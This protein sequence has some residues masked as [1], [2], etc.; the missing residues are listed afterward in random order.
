M[1][2]CFRFT[3]T[4]FFNKILDGG[5]GNSGVSWEPEGEPRP[6]KAPREYRDIDLSPNLGGI[7]A[8]YIKKPR[9]QPLIASLGAVGKMPAV[10]GYVQQGVKLFIFNFASLV[11]LYQS[12]RAQTV[13]KIL[14]DSFH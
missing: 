7:P 13:S 6:I 12:I 2:E 3:R 5:E 10:L 9:P 4:A 8:R 11:E 1:H 14:F